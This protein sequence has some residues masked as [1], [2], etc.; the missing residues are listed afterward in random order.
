MMTGAPRPTTYCSADSPPAAA[1]ACHPSGRIGCR[2]VA[3]FLL[4]QA[5]RHIRRAFEP[6][7]KTSYQMKLGENRPLDQRDQNRHFL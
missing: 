1:Y 4:R 3:A 2:Q 7:H 5:R 6:A